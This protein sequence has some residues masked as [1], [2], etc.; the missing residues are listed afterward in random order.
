[1]EGEGRVDPTRAR[2]AYRSVWWQV[3]DDIDAFW[4]CFHHRA[5]SSNLLVDI[6]DNKLGSIIG[7]LL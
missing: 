2:C 3:A 4:V 6:V 5:S 7:G 1:M